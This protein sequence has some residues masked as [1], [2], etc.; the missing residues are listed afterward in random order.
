MLVRETIETFLEDLKRQDSVITKFDPEAF[1][2]LV[3]HVTVYGADDRCVTFKNGQ[4]IRAQKRRPIRIASPIVIRH[5]RL[6]VRWA[7]LLQN[8][9]EVP[10]DRLR[11]VVV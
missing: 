8:L 1:C 5:D 7:D 11:V 4:E 9:E 6:P 2:S 3:D 10:A